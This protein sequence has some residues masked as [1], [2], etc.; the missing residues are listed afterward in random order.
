MKPEGERGGKGMEKVSE[1]INL[2]IL[3]ITKFIEKHAYI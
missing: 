1:K 2:K 3:Q